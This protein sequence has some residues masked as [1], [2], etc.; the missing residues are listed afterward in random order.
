VARPL[1]ER[2]QD[3]GFSVW[4]DEFE[5]VVGDRLSSSIDRGLATSRSGVVILSPGFVGRSWTERELSGLVARETATGEPLV[6][7]V[8]H[9]VDRDQ[10][11]RFSPP[12]ADVLAVSTDEGLDAVA[13]ALAPAIERR[14][15]QEQ[16]AG[17][18]LPAAV[19]A[20]DAQ[21]SISS[22]DD[23]KLFDFDATRLADFSIARAYR[24]LE[25][26]GELY[27]AQLVIALWLD[28]WRE[29]MDARSWDDTPSED[30]FDYAVRKIHLRQ[31]DF[32]PAGVFYR[33]TTGRDVSET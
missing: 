19:V 13:D 17:R 27:R 18:P 14:R 29:R 23:G 8:W 16:L 25:Q 12:L 4:F 10:I 32:L 24:F 1:A 31:G 26:H 28:G 15:S 5:L 33:E 7:P 2:L 6:L 21:R 9:G 3:R 11:V 20:A 22:V 30:A